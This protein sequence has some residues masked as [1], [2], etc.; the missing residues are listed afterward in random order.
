VQVI[1]GVNTSTL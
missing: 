1:H